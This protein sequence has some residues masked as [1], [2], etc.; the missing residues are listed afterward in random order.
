[1]RTLKE[2]AVVVVKWN[3]RGYFAKCLFD[4]KAK[5]YC[6]AEHLSWTTQFYRWFHKRGGKKGSPIEVLFL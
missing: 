6:Q 1:M 5:L 2:V 3:S 4:L